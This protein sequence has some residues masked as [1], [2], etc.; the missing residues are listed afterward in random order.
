MY[1]MFISISILYFVEQVSLP[2]IGN[3][4]S[5]FENLVRLYFI[6]I[7]LFNLCLNNLNKTFIKNFDASTRLFKEYKV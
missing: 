7:Y 6:L 2:I 5:H 3:K 1:N 4:L